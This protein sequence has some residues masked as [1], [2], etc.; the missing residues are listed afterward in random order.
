ML[1]SKCKFLNEYLILSYNA[2]GC[3][4]GFESFFIGNFY[5]LYNTELLGIKIKRKDDFISV[6]KTNRWPGSPKG[7]DLFSECGL[8]G[9]H[10]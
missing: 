1:E 8:N 4:M 6:S 10:S 9:R 5:F 3:C 7:F 2:P